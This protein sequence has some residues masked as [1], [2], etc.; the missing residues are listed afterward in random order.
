MKLFTSE[1][2]AQGHP[3]RYCDIISNTILDEC[4]KQDPNSR[5]AVEAL[6]KDD[7]VILGGEITTNAQISV[8]Q[9]VDN[10]TKDIGYNWVPKV[11]NYLGQQS[12]DIAL[13]TN[14][15]AN[16]AGDQGI[17]FGYAT[18]EGP[19]YMPLAWSMARDIIKV[20]EALKGTKNYEWVKPDMK[21]Q[22]TIDY[23]LAI[24]RVT[25]VVISIQTEIGTDLSA[26]RPLVKEAIFNLITGKYNEYVNID[27][28]CDILFNETGKFEIGGPFGDAGVTGR[29]IVVDQYGGYAP[30]G[31]GNLNG[32][33]PT[34]VDR[35]AAYMMRYLAKN[36]VANGILSECTIQCGYC[37]GVSQPVSLTITSPDI[38]DDDWYADLELKILNNFDLSPG[39]IIKFLKLKE[40]R[41]VE[42]ARFG[43]YG[44]DYATWEQ[45]DE[46]FK[47]K[48]GL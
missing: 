17:M 33:D 22:V 42:T 16:G 40:P 28:D 14:D 10:V 24:P 43:H 45:I 48:L 47:E 29:K 15:E 26:V 5:V 31:G 27:D 39:G 23:S 44:N 36:L 1:F 21:S 35:S 2:V 37:I 25:T 41:Y 9:I 7:K 34:K 6:A 11:T 38:H 13:G 19:D 4:L 46:N 12:P 3:D 32:K 20:F 18:S 30:V 8:E